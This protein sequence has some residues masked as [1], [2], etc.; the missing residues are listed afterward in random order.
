M[1]I[2]NISYSNQKLERNI[3]YNK[4]RQLFYFSKSSIIF[5]K[6]DKYEHGYRLV[7]QEWNT[8]AS[9]RYRGDPEEFGGWRRHNAIMIIYH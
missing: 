2:R 8:L 5:S 7:P 1:V 3:D 6:S 4:W 9:M